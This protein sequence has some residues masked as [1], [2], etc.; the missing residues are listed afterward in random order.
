MLAAARI[1]SQLVWCVAPSLGRHSTAERCIFA[2][3]DLQRALLSCTLQLFN[4][5]CHFCYCDCL[6]SSSLMPARHHCRIHKPTHARGDERCHGE[7]T[8]MLGA[9]AAELRYQGVHHVEKREDLYADAD[10]GQ[11]EEV[12]VVGRSP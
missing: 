4:A 8:F 5:D 7:A 10:T 11:G 3:L 12:R 2:D 6:S 1:T 9:V